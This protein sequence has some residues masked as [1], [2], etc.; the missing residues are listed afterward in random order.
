[1]LRQVLRRLAGV[2]PDA[3]LGEADI[4]VFMR[5]CAMRSIAGSSAV[6]NRPPSID[7]LNV[8]ANDLTP[9]HI[10]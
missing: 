5:L 4:L 9:F 1:M 10:R 6:E 8:I 2:S 7:S 3:V